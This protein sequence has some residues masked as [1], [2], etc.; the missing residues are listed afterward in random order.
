MSKIINQ[1][2]SLSIPPYKPFSGFLP[3]LENYLRRKRIFEKLTDITFLFLFYW[4][5][6]SALSQTVQATVNLRSDAAYAVL[7]ATGITNTGATTLCGNLGEYSG[8][9]ESGT[10]L[11][12]LSCGGVRHLGDS[13]AQTAQGDLT[14][15][16]ND[17]VNRSG[18]VTFATIYDIGGL[19]L[20]PGL[21]TEPTSLGITGSVTLDGQGNSSAVFIFQIGSTLITAASSQVVLING[22]QAAN[23]FWQ[24]GA[25]CTL[26]INSVFK[27]ALLVDTSITIDS[28]AAFE[29]R[30]LALTGAVGL[31]SNNSTIATPTATSTATLTATSTA[32]PTV[33]P[34]ATPTATLTATP[35]VTLTATPTATPTVTPTSTAVGA[36]GGSGFTPDGVFGANHNA[37]DPAVTSALLYYK[38]SADAHVQLSVY[39]VLGL[40]VRKLVDGDKTAGTWSVPWDGRNDQGTMVASDVYFI[41]IKIGENNYVRKIAVLRGR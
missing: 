26:G 34:T 35:T 8:S 27:G 6:G 25:S 41:L 33:T 19:T 11:V 13:T 3:P 24:V 14:L 7:A 21:Y 30:A 15:A 18:G 22:A 36:V 39:N 1:V 2:R 37:F 40:R 31:T 9:A 16:Y 4:V 10:P 12:V 20:T 17:A 29:G 38:T 23:I 5:C 28:S 32:T